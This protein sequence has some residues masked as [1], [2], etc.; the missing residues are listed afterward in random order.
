M[1][2][3]YHI[4]NCGGPCIGKQSIQEYQKNIQQAREI[5]KG[6][7]RKIL[8]EMKEEMQALAEELR[9]EEAEMIKRKYE[10]ISLYAAKSE[11]VSHV[12]DNIDVLSITSDEDSIYKLY[13]RE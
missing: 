2:L 11:V 10:L 12:V 6:N 5:L 4:K 9:F 1:C 13:T 3:D 7:T 8:R